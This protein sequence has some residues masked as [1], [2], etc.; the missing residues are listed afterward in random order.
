MVS[1]CSN[2]KMRNRRGSLIIEYAA[3]L[4]VIFPIVFITVFTC[5]E[6]SL[7][8]MIFNALNQSSHSAAM[9]LA[10]AY[11]SDP[12]VASDTSKQTS[13]LQNVTFTN[14][15]VSTNQFTVTFPPNPQTSSWTDTTGNVPIVLVTCTYT[16]GQNGLAPFPNP[17]P[18]NLGP[19]ISLQA[20]AVAFLE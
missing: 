8:F 4:V 2:R 14:M 9:I 17:D 12:S 15:V 7:A 6:M 3:A 1:P 16:G 18:L 13:Y 19:K 11:G 5:Y 10:K 20:T